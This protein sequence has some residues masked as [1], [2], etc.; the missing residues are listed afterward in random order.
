RCE[1]RRGNCRPDL[2]APA[3]A[4]TTA[5]PARATAAGNPPRL[6]AVGRAG[7]SPAPASPPP[8][9]RGGSIGR[10]SLVVSVPSRIM[11]RRPASPQKRIQQAVQLLL[12]QMIHLFQA[13]IGRQKPRWL[14]A[15][16]WR[17]GECRAGPVAD[18][19][20]AQSAQEIDDGQRQPQILLDAITKLDA[21]Q[22]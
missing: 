10:S 5:T 3:R 8:A 18:F 14:V 21:R 12:R 6:P 22:G 1:R 17:I 4:K 16:V 9:W 7:V 15:G 11:P 13:E 19:A 20:E 2:S